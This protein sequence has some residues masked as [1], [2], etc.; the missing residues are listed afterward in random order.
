VYAGSTLE[1]CS[2]ETSFTVSITDTPV[3]APIADVTSCDSYTLPSVAGLTYYSAPGAGSTP[4]TT[5]SG[6]ATV[7][8]YMA[9]SVPGCSAEVSFEVTITPSPVLE[10]SG[11]CQDNGYV[12]DAT[13]TNA[14]AGATYSYSW[15][16]DTGEFTGSSNEPSVTVTGAGT[17]T[18]TVSVNGCNG[19]KDSQVSS[20][21]CMIQ[22][23]ISVNGDGKNDF[24]DLEGFNVS[25]LD[26]FNRYG[27]KVYSRSNY[28]NE[29]VG[30][31]DK[32]DELPDGTYYYVIGFESGEAAKTGWIYINR[33]N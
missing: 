16:S 19:E 23:G 21:S 18:V 7:Y 8:A 27:M 28:T 11:G 24:F 32:G 9:G 26:I 5:V 33:E 6:T 2:A 15:T 12:L 1:G 17:Y 22:K 30:Q 10:I 29:W 3:L 20:T 25:Q 31:S 14:V 4:I 13:V